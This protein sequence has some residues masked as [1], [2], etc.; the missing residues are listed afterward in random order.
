MSFFD[1]Y[2]SHASALLATWRQHVAQRRA[3]ARI[4]DRDLGDLGLSPG[5]AEWEIAKPFWKE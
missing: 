3:L 1:A 5:Q 4:S 2:A